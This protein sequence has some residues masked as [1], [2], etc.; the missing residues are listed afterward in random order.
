MFVQFDEYFMLDFWYALCYNKGT[1]G[2]EMIKMKIYMAGAFFRPETKSRIDSYAAG[3]RRLGYDV[4]VPQEHT[5]PNAWEMSQEDWAKEVFK[6]DIAAIQ[7]CDMLFVVYDGLY[8][9]SGTAWE[10]G[11]AY[12]LGKEIQIIVNDGVKDM[13]IMPFSSAWAIGNYKNIKL[14]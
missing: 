3:F 12:A 7:E 4:Y 10:I 6:M 9:D 2:K 5:V 13:S 8:S 1:K 11:Y 14:V